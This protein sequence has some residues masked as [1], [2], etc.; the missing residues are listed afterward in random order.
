MWAAVTVAAVFVALSM[1]S[2]AL[3]QGC[4]MCGNV[5]LRQRS[6]HRG[7]QDQHLVSDGHA[8]A[9]VGSVG[10]WVAWM[11]RRHRLRRTALPA[12]QVLQAEGEAVS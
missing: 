8:V 6:A 2:G 11:Y 12:M 7:V 9:V 4:A 1:P 10:G 3:A 5:P